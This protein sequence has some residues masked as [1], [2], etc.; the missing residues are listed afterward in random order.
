M[1]FTG[2]L[3]EVLFKRRNSVPLKYSDDYFKSKSKDSIYEKKGSVGEVSICL[4]LLGVK[5]L[6][7]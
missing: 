7:R 1:D 3:S 4:L 2:D 5:L 6:H